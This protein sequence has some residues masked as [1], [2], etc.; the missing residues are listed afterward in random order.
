MYYFLDKPGLLILVFFQVVGWL[1]LVIGLI[2]LVIIIKNRISW[3]SGFSTRKNVIVSVIMFVI[4]LMIL[5]LLT[6]YGD[7][8]MPAGWV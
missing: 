2:K 7:A 6:L 8:L 1:I 3:G 5:I 4:G